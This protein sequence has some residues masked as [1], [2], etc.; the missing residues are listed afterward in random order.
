MTL[1]PP[2]HHVGGVV[3]CSPSS[4]WPPATQAPSSVLLS[5]AHQT[6]LLLLTQFRGACLCQTAWTTSIQAWLFPLSEWPSGVA[7]SFHSREQEPK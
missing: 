4:R 3:P 1:P 6:D 7:G 5:V 2:R